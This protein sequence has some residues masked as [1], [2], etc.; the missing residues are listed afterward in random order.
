MFQNQ[1]F[2]LLYFV[3]IDECAEDTDNC[4]DECFDTLGSY[5]CNCSNFVGHKLDSDGFNCVG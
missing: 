3:D 5:V 2:H 4:E 1:F